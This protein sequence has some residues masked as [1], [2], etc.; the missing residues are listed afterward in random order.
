MSNKY[1]VKDILE[2]VDVFLSKKEIKIKS[3]KKISEEPLKLT[4]EI[5][6]IKN[7]KSEL[8]KDTEDIIAQAEE[9]LKK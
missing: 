8:P 7:K 5:K 3:N 1:L 4:N 6:S 2:A 9:Y